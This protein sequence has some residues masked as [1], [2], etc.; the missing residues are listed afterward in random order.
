MLARSSDA[1]YFPQ[2]IRYFGG[3][4]VLLA[5]PLVTMGRVPALS[6]R[7]L[8]AAITVAGLAYVLSPLLLTY[9]LRVLP[10]GFAAFVYC[11][12]P[13]WLLL[14]AYRAGR[15]KSNQF[16]I[17]T[18]GIVVL[19]FGS[20]DD[21]ELRGDS[22]VAS[23]ALAGSVICL[24]L[25]IWVSK[26]LFWLHSALDLNF[27]HGDRSRRPRDPGPREQRGAACDGMEQG[28]LAVSGHSHVRCHGSGLYLYRVESMRPNTVVILT[29]TVPLASLFWGWRL[30]GET[31]M[32]SITLGG[33]AIVLY[34]LTTEVLMG[35]PSQWMCL[36]LNN[37]KRQG[38][39]LLCVL[40][41]FMRPI[42]AGK[43]ARVQVI[44]LSI[45]G[46][47]FRSETPFKMGEQ[48]MI[49][50]PL[51]HNWSS[52]TVDGQIVHITDARFRDFPW[53]GGIEFRNLSLHRRQCLVEFLARLSKAEEDVGS[54][55]EKAAENG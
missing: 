22:L 42:K 3:A 51:G 37:D 28:V 26:R 53:L 30:W 13:M 46:L 29:L 50:L 24:L 34:I 2:A 17:L 38:D 55:E 23:A 35:T 12:L 27:G 45:G 1:I 11:T 47:G 39:R 8:H 43:P 4:V 25:G 41:A 21:A 19:Y 6:L 7:L 44:N 48:V 52:V 32:S 40:D 54:L 9:A 36:S 33:A 5:I 18:V 20:R 16:M 14:V 31:P 49:T 10:S 15:E